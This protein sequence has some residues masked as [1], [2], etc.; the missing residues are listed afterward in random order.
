[1]S[2]ARVCAS[3]DVPENMLKKFDVSGIAIVIANYGDG[4]RAF[5]PFCP[6]MEEP[7]ENSGILAGGMLTCSKHLWQWDLRSGDLIGETEKALLF[8]DVKQEG[9]DILAN[10]ETELSYGYEIEDDMVDDDFFNAD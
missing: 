3:G 9:A 6:H 4:F 7:L 5:P 10:I 8:Y 1:M 2:W